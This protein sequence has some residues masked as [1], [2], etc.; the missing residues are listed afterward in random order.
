MGT[1]NN[2]KIDMLPTLALFTIRHAK[3]PTS[4]VQAVEKWTRLFGHKTFLI[5]L[6]SAKKR[7]GGILCFNLQPCG[8]IVF[9]WMNARLT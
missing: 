6:N 5:I 3:Y 2:K 7:E 4:F 9:K 8:I 1:T